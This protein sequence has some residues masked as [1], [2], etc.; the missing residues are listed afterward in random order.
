MKRTVAVVYDDAMLEHAPDGYDPERPEWTRIVKERLGPHDEGGMQFTHP[1]RPERLRA[2]VEAL[3]EHPVEGLEWIR[4]SPADRAAK[5][6]VHTAEHVDRIESY[7]G[8]SGWLDVDT[9][10]VSEGSVHAADVAVG[11]AMRAAE[12]AMEGQ[13]AFALVRPPGHHCYADH[14]C[15]F[16]LYNNVAVAA[17]HARGSLGSERVLIVDWDAHHGNGT[18]AIFREDPSVMCFDIHAEAP[19]YPGSGPLHD[20][21]SGEAHGTTINVPVPKGTGDVVPV[22][23]L[24]RILRPAAERFAPDLVLVSA[25][26]DGHA[27]DLLMK[28]TDDGYAAMTGILL[29]LAADVAGGRIGFVLEGGYREALSKSVR[30]CLAV[31]AGAEPP[32]IERGADDPGREALALACTFH[33]RPIYLRAS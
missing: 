31:M 5:L 7:R 20:T 13:R 16:C 1:E 8:R 14:P 32:A 26:F 29:E 28:Q 23:A 18:Q 6:L 15:G 24:E 25:G 33:N 17:A 21:G 2:I 30:A 10:A 12:L 9:T 4:P 11:A 3:E 27:A 19:I 22:E